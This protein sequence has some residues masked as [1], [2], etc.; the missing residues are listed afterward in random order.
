MDGVLVS[1]YGRAAC[2]TAGCT[3]ESVAPTAAR[4]APS[5]AAPCIT[6]YCEYVRPNSMIPK[7]IRNRIV[8]TI[9][10]ST[11]AAPSSRPSR[12]PIGDPRCPRLEQ[13][14]DRESERHRSRD[15][16]EGDQGEEQAIF[17]GHHAPLVAGEARRDAGPRGAGLHVQVQHHVVV[18]SLRRTRGLRTW[19]VDQPVIG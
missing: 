18:T 9:A 13:A 1:V 19:R 3:C 5:R 4:R 11:A 16:G 17:G 2:V 8:E 15:D 6:S 14:G 7:T 12:L 10:N